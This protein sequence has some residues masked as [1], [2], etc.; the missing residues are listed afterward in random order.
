MADPITS[1]AS[2]LTDRAA[3]YGKQLCSHLGRKAIA[4]WDAEDGTGRIGFD[5][6]THVELVAAPFSLD[7]TLTATEENVDLFEDVVGRH[8]VRF[9][10]KDELEVTW[11]RSDGTA[12]TRQIN[13]T[14]DAPAPGTTTEERA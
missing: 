10:A 6:A 5:D 4:V 1:T 8:L 9:G 7:F 11:Q 3:R 14:N 13:D 2:V 12:G